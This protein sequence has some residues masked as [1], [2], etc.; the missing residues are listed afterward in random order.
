M[1]SYTF[2]E[3]KMRLPISGHGAARWPFMTHDGQAIQVGLSGWSFEGRKDYSGEYCNRCSSERKHYRSNC[4]DES[5]TGRREMQS[6]ACRTLRQSAAHAV[7]FF[8]SGVIVG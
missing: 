5:C 6:K 4:D 7:R 1:C 8:T 2:L 3:I